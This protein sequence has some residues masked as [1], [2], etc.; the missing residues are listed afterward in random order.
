MYG[1]AYTELCAAIS[2]PRP[3][4]GGGIT[5]TTTTTTGKFRGSS[6]HSGLG[7]SL[8]VASPLPIRSLEGSLSHYENEVFQITERFQRITVHSRQMNLRPI[9]AFYRHVFYGR[10]HAV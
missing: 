4:A 10:G 5:T 3:L 6:H 1:R 9:V 8:A 2:P 7:I